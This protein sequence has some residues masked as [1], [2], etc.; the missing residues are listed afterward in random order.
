MDWKLQQP[1]LSFFLFFFTVKS[2][3]QSLKEAV[4]QKTA[5]K[6]LD[7]GRNKTEGEITESAGLSG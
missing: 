6:A 4:A 5:D 7:G 1:E 3:R 2:K